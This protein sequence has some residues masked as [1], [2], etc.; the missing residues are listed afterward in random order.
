MKTIAIP[1]KYRN[2]YLFSKPYLAIQLNIKIRYLRDLFCKKYPLDKSLK[3]K[4]FQ[5]KI[6]NDW[7]ID[8]FSVTKKIIR[9]LSNVKK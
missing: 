3:I 5:G 2:F 1:Y 7:L 6:Q 9:F 8:I 4:E